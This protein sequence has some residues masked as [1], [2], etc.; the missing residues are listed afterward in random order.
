V[1]DGKFRRI[2]MHVDP[3]NYQLTYRDG[4]Y[5]VPPGKLSTDNPEA[6]SP[7]ATA[8]LHG[9]PPSTQIVFHA[10]VVPANDPSLQDARLPQGP[11]GEKASNLKGPL[12]TYVIDVS[13]DPHS[14]VLG[15]VSGGAQEAQLKFA[16]I[17]YDAE[18]K[19]VNDLARDLSPKIPQEAFEQAMAHD[20]DFRL[21]LD[22]PAGKNSLRIG[23]EDA[24]SGRTGSLE[25]PLTVAPN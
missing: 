24:N 14:L 9:A 17:A 8:M 16:L 18:G 22:L 4:Y 10:R 11:A 7:L 21:A 12:E 13:I 25:I 19:P 2:Q 5:A 1:F 6:V 15:A 20:M 3:G 23:V